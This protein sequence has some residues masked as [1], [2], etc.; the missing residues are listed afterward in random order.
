MRE[1]GKEREGGREGAREGGSEGEGGGGSERERR[2]KEEEASLLPS[3]R[4]GC[5]TVPRCPCCL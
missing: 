1:G 4:V 2:L 5:P 3:S